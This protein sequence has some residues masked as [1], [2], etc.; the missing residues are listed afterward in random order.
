MNMKLSIAFVT[1]LATFVV[2]SGTVYAHE[3]RLILRNQSLACEG[4][5]IWKNSSY[6]IEGRCSGL[7]YPYAERLSEYYLWVQPEAGGPAERVSSI[8]A[9]YFEGRADEPFTRAFITV[10]A[11][12]VRQPGELVLASGEV[13]GFNFPEAATTSGITVRPT[14]RISPSPTPRITVTPRNLS[15]F[16]TGAT[17]LVL[18]IVAVAIGLG[19][20][21]LILRYFS[22]KA[23]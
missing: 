12:R 9:G 15:T 16:R 17:R 6:R 10:E 14:P 8:D 5:S 23:N 19:L 4:I 3:G 11:N 21:I 18:G 20:A 7:V 22:K 13:S 1:L 2:F